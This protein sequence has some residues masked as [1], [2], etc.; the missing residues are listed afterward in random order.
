MIKLYQ[1]AI[2]M[3]EIIVL[4]RSELSSI[5]GECIGRAFDKLKKQEPVRLTQPLE[6]DETFTIQGLAK[7]WNC[8][9][10]TIINKKNSGVIPFHQIGKKVFFKK[11]EV[12]A[13]TAIPALKNGGPNDEQSSI[14]STFRLA[15]GQRY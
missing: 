15:A 11:S 2:V 4:S 13:I 7:Y 14:Q 8:H 5:I 6:D 9:Y 10:Q 1:K 3:S 12:D